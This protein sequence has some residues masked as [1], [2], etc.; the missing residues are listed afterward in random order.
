MNVQTDEGA[1]K[2]A[3]IDSSRYKNMFFS[4]S[5]M[6]LEIGTVDSVSDRERC[7]TLRRGLVIW[8]VEL[9]RSDI[10]DKKKHQLLELVLEYLE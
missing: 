8:C 4:V 6:L 5:E 3:G 1:K 10:P 7:R 9:S 2:T